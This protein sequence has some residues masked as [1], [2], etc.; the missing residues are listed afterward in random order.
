VPGGW[1]VGRCVVIEATDEMYGCFEHAGD[2]PEAVAM[3]LAIAE[4]DL[5]RSIA[6]EIAVA[7]EAQ[8]SRA[9]AAHYK[10]A[11]TKAARIARHH[12]AGVTGSSASEGAE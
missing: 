12:G 3:V 8:E 9:K 1:I 10:A 5:R 6:E 4:R 7:I 11:L 2:I